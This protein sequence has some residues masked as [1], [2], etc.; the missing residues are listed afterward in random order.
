MHGRALWRRDT[1]AALPRRY[2]W[3][4]DPYVYTAEGRFYESGSEHKFDLVAEWVDEHASDC[5]THREPAYPAG[6]CDR[7]AEAPA[8]TEGSTQLGVEAFRE[9]SGVHSSDYSPIRASILDE[10]RELTVSA[11]QSEY[12]PPSVNFACAAELK[13]VFRK[14]AKRDITPAEMEALDMLFTKLGR[15]ATGAVKRDNYVDGA[16]YI[17]LA[18]EIALAPSVSNVLNSD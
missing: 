10:A 15:I 16:G 11:R 17:A 18:G 8:E 4:V 12:G 14:H 7:K 5:A 13:T 3:R 2:P 9:W 6:T 1:H